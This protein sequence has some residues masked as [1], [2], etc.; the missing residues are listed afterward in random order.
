[1]SDHWGPEEG[2]AGPAHC[3]ATRHDPRRTQCTG[4]QASSNG[5]LSIT[6]PRFWSSSRS[7]CPRTCTSTPP[8]RASFGGQ[9]E[10]TRRNRPRRG[11]AW[12]V[13]RDRGPCNVVRRA[14]HSA[15]PPAQTNGPNGPS[16]ALGAFPKLRVAS[17]LCAAQRAEATVDAW[18][19]PGEGR[20]P[21]SYAGG[22]GAPGVRVPPSVHSSS[23]PFR[24]SPHTRRNRA[25]LFVIR[26][27]RN[28]QVA[29]SNPA[30][31]SN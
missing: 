20:P 22:E 1:M 10:T 21:G 27:L 24:S 31:G 8:G 29:G 15:A 2:K 11:A 30:V 9:A 3:G 14:P 6:P 16:F 13:R 5:R 26:P 25:P 19:L 17:L 18:R 4:R 7:A 12:A 28:Q 23:A